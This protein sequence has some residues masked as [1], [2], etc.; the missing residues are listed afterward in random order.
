M[1]FYRRD[2]KYLCQTC[3]EGAFGKVCAKCGLGIETSSKSFVLADKHWH[4]SCF[5]C[6]HCNESLAGSP[7]VNHETGLY[8]PNCYYEVLG[9]KCHGCKKPLGSEGWLGLLYCAMVISFQ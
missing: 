6:S 7:M 4:D 3:F 2:E 8:C 5:V 1:P 9:E